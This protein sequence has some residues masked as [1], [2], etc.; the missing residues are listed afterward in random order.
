[1]IEVFTLSPG[2]ID[3]ENNE[4]ILTTAMTSAS[5][6]VKLQKDLLYILEFE[7]SVIL[8]QLR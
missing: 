7:H 8:L 2:N 3:V 5:S 1:M 6:I 4:S